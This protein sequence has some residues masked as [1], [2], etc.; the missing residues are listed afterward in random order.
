MIYVL[1][2]ILIA[3]FESRDGSTIYLTTINP[4]YSLHH[5]FVFW[6][7]GTDRF[8]RFYLKSSLHTMPEPQTPP[9]EAPWTIDELIRQRATLDPDAVLVAY[10]DSTGIYRDYTAREL[11]IYACRLALHYR[12]LIK[13]RAGSHEPTKVVGLHGPSDIGYLLSAIALSKLGFT[14]LFLSTRLSGVAYESLL[15]STGCRDLLVA[16]SLQRK[17]EGISESEHSLNVHSIAAPALYQLPIKDTEESI[18]V[19]AQLDPVKENLNHAWIIHSSGSTGPP[20]VCPR[21]FT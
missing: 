20:K 17:I 18:S 1:R 6:H 4:C 12:G 9:E 2:R 15:S 10:P 11:D 19:A 13:I 14:V 21:P 5:Y 16:D 3:T 8:R 7:S